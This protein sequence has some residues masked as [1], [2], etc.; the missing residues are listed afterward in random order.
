MPYRLISCTALLASL[1]LSAAVRAHGFAGKRFFPST[2]AVEDPFVSDELSW[3]GGWFKEPGEEDGPAVYETELE[4]EYSKRLTEHFGLS[5]GDAWRN[6]N[7]QGA[8]A[9]RSGLANLVLGGRYQF[10][11]S[12]PHEF[13]MSLGLEAAIGGTGRAT[14][15][16]EPFTTLSPALLF[17]KGFGDLPDRWWALKPLAITGV[18]SANVPLQR[19]SRGEEATHLNPTSLDWGL[20]L[21]YNVHY[22]QSYVKDTAWGRPFRRMIPVLEMAMNTCLDRGCSGRTTGSLNPGLIWFGDS[23]QLGL[24]AQIPVNHRTGNR[25]GVLLQVH[26]FIDDLFPNT[27]GRPLFHD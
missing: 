25:V 24:E 19:S 11:T 12:D 5:L 16:G 1:V 3:V 15:E 21:E 2:L 17:G 13:L 14:V 27:L 10:V 6:R 4:G 8:G 26:F 23:F 7:P 18:V 20:A 22:L 9:T